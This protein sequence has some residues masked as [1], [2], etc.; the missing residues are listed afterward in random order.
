[1]TVQKELVERV[2]HYFALNVYETKVWLALLGKGSASIADVAELSKVPRSRIYDVLKT[3]ERKGFCVA[4]LGKPI[5]YIAV[6][7]E[8][9]IERL[10]KDAEKG[11]KEQIDLLDRVKDTDEYGR[12]VELFESNVEPTEMLGNVVRGRK[13][14]ES[15]ILDMI[16]NASEKVVLVAGGEA[17]KGIL[18][19]AGGILNR[20]VKKGLKVKI[21]S[22]GNVD[23]FGG[24][25]KEGVKVRSFD[26]D[27]RFCIADSSVL[28]MTTPESV[29]EDADSG[30]VVESGFFANALEGLFDGACRK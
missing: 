26:T 7:P 29:E 28:F 15:Q 24:Q 8:V 30:V 17:L 2:K 9:V 3:L 21:G 18:D 5:K 19:S 13:N 12:I 6:K 11:V 14:V 16:G 10:K 20:R 27:A 25:V 23:E 4:R 1:M 22:V